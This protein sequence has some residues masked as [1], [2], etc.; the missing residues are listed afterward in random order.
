[1]EEDSI[2]SLLSFLED[3]DAVGLPEGDD[4]IIWSLSSSG[5]FSVKGLCETLLGSNHP[6]FPV[7]A[8]WKSKNLDLNS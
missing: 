8:I 6:T 5:V 4:K 7:K 1:M 2:I 3:W